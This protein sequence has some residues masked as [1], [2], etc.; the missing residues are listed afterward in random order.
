[1]ETR[2]FHSNVKFSG[3]RPPDFTDTTYPKNGLKSDPSSLLDFIP[4]SIIIC[5][6]RGAVIIYL[7][8]IVIQCLTEAPLTLEATIVPLTMTIITSTIIYSVN[9]FSRRYQ[10]NLID[11]RKA[12]VL[13]GEKWIPIPWENIYVGDLIKFKNGDVAPADC[14]LLTT[15]NKTP[16][17]IGTHAIDGSNQLKARVPFK[18]I[19]D[20]IYRTPQDTFPLDFE[21]NAD[22]IRGTPKQLNDLLDNLSESSSRKSRRESSL[23][24]Q[25]KLLFSG[26][27]KSQFWGNRELTINQAQY[28]ERYSS[29]YHVGEVVAAVV[30]TGNDVFRWGD[31]S[32]I[33]CYSGLERLL[34]ALIGIQSIPY[35]LTAGIASALSL[36]YY[37]K[38]SEWPF[39]SKKS[40]TGYAVDVFY[41][42]LVNLMS[43]IPIEVYSFLDII[44]FI[45]FLFIQHEDG[46][47][48]QSISTIDGLTEV[49]SVVTSKSSIVS[50]SL[51]IKKIFMDDKIFVSEISTSAQQ[52]RNLSSSLSKNSFIPMNPSPHLSQKVSISPFSEL[53][54][55]TSKRDFFLHLCLCHCAMPIHQGTYY[56]YMSNIPEDE[57]LL[58]LAMD[59]RFWLI[60]RDPQNI[61]I[62]I[63]QK[64]TNSG[65]LLDEPKSKLNYKVLRMINP[66]SDH[67]WLTTIIFGPEGLTFYIRGPAESILRTL[68]YIPAQA[69]RIISDFLQ[70]GLSPICCAYKRIP[71]ANKPEIQ[72]VFNALQE[73]AQIR[74]PK[75]LQNSISSF[76]DKFES[77]S[78]FLALV[79]MEEEPNAGVVN[80]FQNCRAA[81]VQ[82]ILWTQHSSSSLISTAFSTGAILSGE[83]FITID[84]DDP[85]TVKRG[86]RT[87]IMPDELSQNY[88]NSLNT[89]DLINTTQSFK[90]LSMTGKTIEAISQIGWT[91]RN[92][93]FKMKTILV[94]KASPEQL[95]Q[96][97][98]ILEHMSDKGRVMGI[99]SSL[100]DTKMLKKCGLSISMELNSVNPSSLCSDIIV[101]KFDT[102]NKIMFVT[103]IWLRERISSFLLFIF[104]RNDVFALIQFAYGI[105]CCFSGTSLWKENQIWL[106]LLVFTMI[107]ALSRGIFNKKQTRFELLQHP[108]LY[109][110]YRRKIYPFP[111]IIN[112]VFAV[113]VAFALMEISKL[114]FDNARRPYGDSFSLPQFSFCVQNLFIYGTIAVLVPFIQTWTKWQHVLTWGIL[115]LFLIFNQ[116]SFGPL[117]GQWRGVGSLWNSFILF[118]L[119][120]FVVGMGLFISFSYILIHNYARQRKQAINDLL[121]ATPE[122]TSDF[123][124]IPDSQ[125]DPNE[126]IDY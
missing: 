89:Y 43:F 17:A 29:I 18:I 41:R 22:Y 38:I 24:K 125:Q 94:S 40:K 48:V 118:L 39:F 53:S 115:I 105:H 81:D 60:S 51:S 57:P 61:T 20:S 77:N 110:K 70:D 66:S 107:P 90:G 85:E 121:T 2:S 65:E 68:G 54:N 114:S 91:I 95:A 44:L 11:R 36:L 28:I 79:G 113:I 111:F 109:G 86:L 59:F 87:Y 13:R 33:M 76:L 46:C 100:K 120:L 119:K 49:S 98:Q 32:N 10:T 123:F 103:G 58:K 92:E 3:S 112:S 52:A 108:E 15:S 35:V 12:L 72:Q 34:N 124:S 1:M 71:I 23:D 8:I 64:T 122:L 116:I 5:F 75:H 47:R 50:N 56:G 19:S 84:S 14:I 101:Q 45:H 74:D 104:P 96:L 21:M 88:T 62:G 106:T 67:P 4:T 83:N 99:G 80:F 7:L 126:D 30:Y 31:T 9:F 63:D 73:L 25:L 6:G 78:T 27:F 82:L 55:S 37:K 16:C 69:K 93:I 42:Y 26:R 97:V 102:L 117:S